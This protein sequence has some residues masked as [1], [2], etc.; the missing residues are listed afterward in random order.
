MR[1]A[2]PVSISKALPLNVLVVL[3]Q[4]AVLATADPEMANATTRTDPSRAANI[5]GCRRTA[6]FLLSR[7]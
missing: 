5:S 2:S 3:V 6:L 7:R 1:F 4:A